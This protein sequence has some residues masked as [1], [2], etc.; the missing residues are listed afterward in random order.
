MMKILRQASQKKQEEQPEK[1][2]RLPLRWVVIIGLAS[3]TGVFV[4]TL[5]SSVATGFGAGL[6]MTGL[7]HQVMD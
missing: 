6:A 1:P 2:P 4:G 5:A 3:V 7:L